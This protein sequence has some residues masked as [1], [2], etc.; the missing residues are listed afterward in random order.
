MANIVSTKR[1]YARRRAE[2]CTT[3]QKANFDML[4]GSKSPMLRIAMVDVKTGRGYEVA[5][6]ED[7]T[8]DLM[9]M[10]LKGK[11]WKMDELRAEFQ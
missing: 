11:G 3:E 5:L 2:V 9:R 10:M 8:R 7:E 1:P 4:S 6:T